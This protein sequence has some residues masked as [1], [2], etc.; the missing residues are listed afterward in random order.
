MGERRE[1][2]GQRYGNAGACP[3]VSDA[4]RCEHHHLTHNC[5]TLASGPKLV[6][7]HPIDCKEQ[8][9]K[10]SPSTNESGA[11]EGDVGVRGSATGV[12]G[13]R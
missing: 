10:S 3:R 9:G 7:G 1:D 2:R 12:G 5:V 11:R 8:E 6:S 4:D 13:L